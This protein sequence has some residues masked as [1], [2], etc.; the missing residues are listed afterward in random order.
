MGAT[1]APG[2]SS[3]AALLQANAVSLPKSLLDITGGIPFSDTIF[4]WQSMAT[5]LAAKARLPVSLY[6]SLIVIS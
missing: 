4:L 6:Q 5:T 1:W 3:P 2:P